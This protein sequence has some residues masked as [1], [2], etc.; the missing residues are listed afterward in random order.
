[1]TST[2]ALVTL[3]IVGIRNLILSADV[4]L[5]YLPTLFSVISFNFFFSIPFIRTAKVL[6]A[7]FADLPKAVLI[8]LPFAECQFFVSVS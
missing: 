2:I 7:S 4:R 5:N 3:A 8:Y 6:F 1:M